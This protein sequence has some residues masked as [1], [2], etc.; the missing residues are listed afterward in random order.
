MHL[1]K[2]K[3]VGRFKNTQTK[4]VFNVHQGRVKGRSVDVLFYY[5]RQKRQYI[6]QADFYATDIYEPA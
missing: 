1:T 4:Q 5:Y 2:I 3:L 6:S